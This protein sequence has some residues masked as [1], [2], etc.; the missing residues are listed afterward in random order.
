MISYPKS[1]FFYQYLIRCN[2]VA[3]KIGT[4]IMVQNNIC[5]VLN[6]FRD[7]LWKKVGLGNNV[8]K[9]LYSSNCE[10]L[11][12]IKSIPILR[13]LALHSYI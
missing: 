7:Y 8:V 2:V 9:V 13:R 4:I 10:R 3:Y 1:S 5:T 6:F 12:F 11:W